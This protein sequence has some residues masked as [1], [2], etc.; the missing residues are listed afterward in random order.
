MKGQQEYILLI[1]CDIR[2]ITATTYYLPTYLPTYRSPMPSPRELGVT[3]WSHTYI[4]FFSPPLMHI[5]FRNRAVCGVVG[6]LYPGYMSY[7]A[8]KN[9]D[10][11][12]YVR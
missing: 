1:Q 4:T 8:I 6:A 12:E 3:G 10:I 11:E 9:K 5:F 7:K 2:K